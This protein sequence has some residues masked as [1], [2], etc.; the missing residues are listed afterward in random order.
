MFSLVKLLFVSGLFITAITPSWALAQQSTDESWSE[1]INLSNSGVAIN[2]DLVIDS[3]GFPHA[4]WQDDLANYLYAQFDGEQWGIP[5]S[6]DLNRLFRFPSPDAPVDPFQLMNHTGPN[7]LFLASPNRNVFAF[8]ILPE[9]RVYVSNV[10][11]E[12]FKEYVSWSSVRPITSGA[13]SFTAVVDGRGE[14]H[15]AFLRTASDR[16]NPPGIYYT[17]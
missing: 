9:G 16:T 3:D 17:N 5:E 7:P 13:A 4:V 2:P 11:N 10:E 14:L 15:V 12:N 1:P 6:T 8:W